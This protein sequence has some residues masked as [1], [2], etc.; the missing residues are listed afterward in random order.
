M[1]TDLITLVAALTIALATNLI[2][3]VIDVRASKKRTERTLR[4]LN[5]RID[6]QRKGR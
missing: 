4:Q 2:F 5:H 6:I 1:N 3:A